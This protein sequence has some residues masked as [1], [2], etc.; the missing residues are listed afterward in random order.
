MYRHFFLKKFLSCAKASLPVP[1]RRMEDEEWFHGVLPREEVQRLLTTDGDYL[2]RESKNR[3][4]N[5]TQYV[6]S[7]YWQGHKHFIIQ[8]A[9]VGFLAVSLC[10]CLCVSVNLCVCFFFLSLSCL[11]LPWC[12]SLPFLSVCVC[13]LV[14]HGPSQQSSKAVSYTHLTLPTKVVV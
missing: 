2:V 10:L 13:L 1:Q 6:L 4:T 7:V 5:E 3:K 9:E 11:S 8:G 14:N 12:L